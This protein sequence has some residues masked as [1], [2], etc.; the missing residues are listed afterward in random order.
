MKKKYMFLFLLALIVMSTTQLLPCTLYAKEKPN[1]DTPGTAIFVMAIPSEIS[2]ESKI[3]QSKNQE[4][5]IDIKYP[6][7]EGLRDKK[8]ERIINSYLKNNS[9]QSKRNLTKEAKLYNQQV[10]KTDFPNRRYELIQNFTVKDTIN[11][12]FVLE[13]FEYNYRGGAH[14]VTTQK[15]IVIDLVNNKIVMLKELFDEKG[16]YIDEINEVIKRQIS[17]RIKEGTHFFQGEEGFSSINDETQFYINS[18]GNL[19][20]VFNVYEIGP[21]SSGAYQFNISKK[22]LRSYRLKA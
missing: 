8:F 4:I 10:E 21:Y 22:D 7:L 17:E 1:K 2:V 5:N 6:K 14:G 15:Y 18:E 20:I 9:I 16:N 19:V 3:I 11:G 12:Y 13:L